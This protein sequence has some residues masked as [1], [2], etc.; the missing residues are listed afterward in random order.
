MIGDQCTWSGSRRSWP[1]ALG[2][3]LLLTSPA[4]KVSAQPAGGPT[5]D[6]LPPPGYPQGP[7]QPPPGYGPPPTTYPGQTPSMGHPAYS[8]YGYG[9]PPPPY[10]A[11][12]GFYQYPAAPPP[13]P[14]RSVGA[15]VGGITLAATG[16]IA[17]L[18]GTLLF[19]DGQEKT[20]V[21]CTTSIS[22]TLCG[23]R[24]DSARIGGGVALMILGGIGVGVGVPL[25]IWGGSR[26]K[27]QLRVGATSASLSWQY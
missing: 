19:S 21:Y 9:S 22:T 27:P 13:A 8:P 3:A 26:P 10:Y 1:L 24:D 18:S 20:P 11:P 6:A 5:A 4:P 15:L 2:A 23:R 14:Q 17:F 16:A 7:A 25:A 12:P